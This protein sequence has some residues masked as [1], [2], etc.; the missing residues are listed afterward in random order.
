M[1]S[2]LVT[3][4]GFIGAHCLIQLLAAGYEA[5]ATVRNLARASDLRAMLRRGEP[6]RWATV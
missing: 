3:G 1:T 4:H 6:A 2:V 5:R